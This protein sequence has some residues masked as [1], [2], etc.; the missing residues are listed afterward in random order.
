M[1]ITD[2]YVQNFKSCADLE[3]S[4]REFN[5][6]IGAMRRVSPILSKF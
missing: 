6:L 4:L 1:A 5:V 2:V 3:L